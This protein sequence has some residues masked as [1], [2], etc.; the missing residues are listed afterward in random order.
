MDSVG[1]L[2]F[3]VVGHNTHCLTHASPL[4]RLA[5]NIT[6]PLET[7]ADIARRLEVWHSRVCDCGLDLG[8][9]E[10]IWTPD[11]ILESALED[12]VVLQD[13]YP[14]ESHRADPH[15]RLVDLCGPKD[16][17]FERLTALF[18]RDPGLDIRRAQF[19]GVQCLYGDV[20][21]VAYD[22]F[23]RLPPP[24]RTDYR[25]ISS[26]PGTCFI[27]K[28]KTLEWWYLRD[29]S[30]SIPII[31]RPA[32]Y[33]KSTFVSMCC[34]VFGD[35]IEHPSVPLR[36][37]FECSS[38]WDC[39]P[40]LLLDFSQLRFADDPSE[41]AMSAVADSFMQR[42]AQALWDRYLPNETYVRDEHYDS[43]HR[44]IKAGGFPASPTLMLIYRL[45]ALS[46]RYCRGLYLAIDNYTHPFLT[47]DAYTCNLIEH[48]IWHRVLA[49]MMDG[50]GDA[51]GV[52]FR[53]VIT[54]TQEHGL[55]P[56]SS[57]PVFAS[58]TTDLTYSAE[59]ASVLGFTV[60]NV[61]DLARA[62]L[63]DDPEREQQFLAACQLPPA[64]RNVLLRTADVVRL[65]QAYKTGQPPLSEAAPYRFDAGGYMDPVE[66]DGP[67]DFI[68]GTGPASQP[69]KAAVGEPQ[70]AGSK[71]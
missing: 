69:T 49:P 46:D 67:S 61:V 32:G 16:G 25:E 4:S 38:N 30:A 17:S 9:S 57:F 26:V 1:D 42:A 23:P 65:M 68:P 21:R 27:D 2:C 59:Y 15:V 18:G 53:G 45:Q 41:K 44:M 60:P 51:A 34:A 31:R 19:T 71:V 54:G 12:N 37:T 66:F 22:P 11:L 52:I 14:H 50:G 29:K 39:R 55:T 64:D 47:A 6:G 58:A 56:F 20:C 5:R 70:E 13:Y 36:P 62:V 43:P 8:L 48:V 33:G 63:R 3:A 7:L 10:N 35:S 28:T 40:A 24:G